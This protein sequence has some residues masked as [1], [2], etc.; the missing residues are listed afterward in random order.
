MLRI[1][2]C[3]GR[4]S[5][6]DVERSCRENDDERRADGRRGHVSG[7]G[8]GVA[9]G[10]RNADLE[11]QPDLGRTPPPTEAHDHRARRREHHVGRS[12]IHGPNEVAA[13]M[14]EPDVGP[15]ASGCHEGRPEVAD[16]HQHDHWGCAD[17]ALQ[18]PDHDR[19]EQDLGK[20][21]RPVEEEGAQRASYARRP[22]RR[23][24]VG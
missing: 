13:A 4:L 21:L 5:W 16:R 9:K 23:S 2:A 15:D 1:A 6:N 18:R 12:D 17:A 8:E 22:T 7:I 19:D 24:G 20:P 3:A 11:G 10:E 14:T